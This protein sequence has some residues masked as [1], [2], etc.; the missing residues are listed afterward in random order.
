M[1]RQ[2]I[3][4]EL[5]GLC[6][7]LFDGWRERRCVISLA[8]LLQV[9]PLVEATQRSFKRLR[10]NLRDLECWH[11]NDVSDEDGGR[12]RYL[13]GV[14]SQQTGSVVSTSTN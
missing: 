12:I 4:I 7:A 11:L 13:L 14:L 10:D 9:W 3:A 8:Y 1:S 2:K 5:N 6:L